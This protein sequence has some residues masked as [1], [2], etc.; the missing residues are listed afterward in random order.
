M[1]RKGIDHC[2]M[3]IDMKDP[4]N[5]RILASDLAF[6]KFMEVE[7]LSFKKAEVDG[8]GTVEIKE[9]LVESPENTVEQEWIVNYSQ[10][11][12]KKTDFE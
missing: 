5:T 7:Q 10:K 8:I 4:E 3:A 12:I 6:K 1:T 9:R 11:V 2:I